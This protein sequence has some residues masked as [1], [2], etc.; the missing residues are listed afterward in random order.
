MSN[1]VEA[2]QWCTRLPNNLRAHLQRALRLSV[3]YIDV[4]DSRLERTAT[5]HLGCQ[6]RK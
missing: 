4:G 3:E 2:G 6:V 5:T 1:A